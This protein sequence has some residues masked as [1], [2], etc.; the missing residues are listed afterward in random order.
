[1]AVVAKVERKHAE[2][3]GDKRL[4][5]R[6]LFAEIA[7]PLVREYDADVPLAGFDCVETN[8]VVSREPE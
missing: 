2:S 4:R 6:K 7:S 5:V 8:A 3:R 1:M